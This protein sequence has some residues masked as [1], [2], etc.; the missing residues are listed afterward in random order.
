M[1]CR[2]SSKKEQQQQQKRA[3]ECGTK[4]G[5]YSPSFILAQEI[6]DQHWCVSGWCQGS[7]PGQGHRMLLML[8][9]SNALQP[10][11]P[12]FRFSHFPNSFTSSKERKHLDAGPPLPPYV[13]NYNPISGPAAPICNIQNAQDPKVLPTATSF[14]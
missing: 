11:F 9:S 3:S 7:R 8:S 1:C 6:Q 14:S 5:L 10:G 2:C 4:N 13:T 12:Q